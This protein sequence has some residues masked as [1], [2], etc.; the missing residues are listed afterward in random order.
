MEGE[1]LLSPLSFI[2]PLNTGKGVLHISGSIPQS[3]TSLLSEQN[4]KFT[5]FSNT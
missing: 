1:A 3:A 2:Q 5:Y 4:M